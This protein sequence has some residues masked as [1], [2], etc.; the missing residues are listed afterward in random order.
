MTPDSV[1]TVAREAVLALLMVSAPAMLV[2]LVVGLLIGLFQALTSIQEV[3]LTFVPKIILVFAALL[4]TMPFMASQ[5]QELTNDLFER[6]AF[7]DKVVSDVSEQ[8]P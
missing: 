5:M 8:A 1:A 6:M 2:A 7:T 4:M 3:T